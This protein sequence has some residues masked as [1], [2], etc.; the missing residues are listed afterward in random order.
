MSKKS[1]FSFTFFLAVLVTQKV[2][3]QPPVINS[4]TPS[5]GPV[6]SL[7][8]ISGSYLNLPTAITVGSINAI[9][10]S[11]S[12]TQAVAL[13]MPGTTTGQVT[14]VTAGGV[15]SGNNNFIISQ[16][17][18]PNK[19]LGN[20]LFGTNTENTVNSSEQGFSVALSADGN[21]AAVGGDFDN[22]DLGSVWI[23]TRNNNIWTQ[24]GDKIAGTGATGT[25]TAQGF[26][27]AISSDGNTF[28]RG[29]GRR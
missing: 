12:N 23:Y 8:T 26:S 7:M 28:D 14:V 16:S 20:K 21:T 9:V 13:V 5:G 24:Q 25:G 6:G 29:W 19:Q 15:A 3:A 2:W 10:I 27:V 18:P 11:A 17:L 22:G 4:F 1:I